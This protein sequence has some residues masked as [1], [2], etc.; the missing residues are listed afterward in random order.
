MIALVLAMKREII[1]LV[2]VVMAFTVVVMIHIVFDQKFKK[3]ISIK[4]LML[5]K[6]GK[7]GREFFEF[8]AHV[9]VGRQYLDHKNDR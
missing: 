8:T 4:S 5:L 7:K 9:H 3:G 6:M 1:I 2:M